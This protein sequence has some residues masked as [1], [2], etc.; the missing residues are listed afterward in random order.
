MLCPNCNVQIIF[1]VERRIIHPDLGE[2]IAKTCPICECVIRVRTI[3]CEE[4][5]A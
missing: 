3:S 4:E 1:L 2:L 5:D